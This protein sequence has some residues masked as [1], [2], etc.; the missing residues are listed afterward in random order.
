MTVEVTLNFDLFLL[1]F[2]HGFSFS[3]GYLVFE[4]L[5]GAV[6]DGVTTNVDP[7]SIDRRGLRQKAA[8]SQK[9]F[10]VPSVLIVR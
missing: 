6:S 7:S 1:C 9:V 3:H 5:L 2:L 4:F 8:F 10:G